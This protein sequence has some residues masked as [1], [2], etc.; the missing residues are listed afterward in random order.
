MAFKPATIFKDSGVKFFA[1]PHYIIGKKFA[2][3]RLLAELSAPALRLYIFVLAIA[4]NDCKPF[5]RVTNQVIEKYA[6]VGRD[7][8]KPAR[9]ELQSKHLVRVSQDGGY[10]VFE[11]LDPDRGVSLPSSVKSTRLDDLDGEQIE[12]V[13]RHYIG[14]K[15]MESDANGLKFVCPFHL[16]IGK[17]KRAYISVKSPGVGLWHCRSKDCVHHGKRKERFDGTGNSWG[18]VEIKT[19]I[20]AGGGGD[21]LDF[22]SAITKK[23]DGAE[24]DRAE[25]G[26]IMNLIL[27]GDADMSLS[28]S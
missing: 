5:A 19:R 17:A 6:S 11:I 8:I 25:A 18:D 10:F 22:I 12:Q 28:P 20:F 21:V 26:R 16:P 23:N 15:Q 3:E 24:I 7:A 13:F 14:D 9:V 4:G 1:V 27:T 2:S